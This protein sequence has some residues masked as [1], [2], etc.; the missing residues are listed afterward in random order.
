MCDCE[1][2]RDVIFAEGTKEIKLGWCV[3]ENC[4]KLQRLVLPST[5]K[6][7]VL[8]EGDSFLEYCPE[9]LVIVPK[10]SFAE[11]FCRKHGI[12]FRYLEEA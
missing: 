5:L 9:A 12:E 1:N 11:K 10:G 4:E 2:L 8:D 7:I 6:S 3:F